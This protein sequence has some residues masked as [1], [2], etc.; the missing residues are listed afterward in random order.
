MFANLAQC[1]VLRAQ[2]NSLQA[3]FL[4][5]WLEFGESDTPLLSARVRTFEGYDGYAFHPRCKECPSPV[6]ED[7]RVAL[8]LYWRSQGWSNT[9]TWPHAVCRW[10]K[11]QLPNGQLTRS[12]W[13]KKNVMSKLCR[14]L[15]V[16]VS[17]TI[18]CVTIYFIN[19]T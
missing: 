4:D 16:E 2:T 12:V 6:S 17:D 1:A 15:C 19:S 11:L 13:H 5:I 3:H 7:E 14:A 18:F 10:A 9:D 8:L